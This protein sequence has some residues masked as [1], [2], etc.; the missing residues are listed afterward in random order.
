MGLYRWGSICHEHWQSEKMRGRNDDENVC[1]LSYISNKH[2]PLLHGLARSFSPLFFPS[3]TCFPHLFYLF[4]SIWQ[5][6]PRSVQSA[7]PISMSK[8]TTHGAHYTSKRE[9][10]LLR[11]CCRTFSRVGSPYTCQNDTPS[12]VEPFQPTFYFD[13]H[14]S[15]NRISS[16]SFMMHLLHIHHRR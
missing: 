14:H 2:P 10:C 16:S 4:L 15:G 8:N 7:V 5:P 1:M 13:H 6:T 12:Y 11:M 3:L 9:L